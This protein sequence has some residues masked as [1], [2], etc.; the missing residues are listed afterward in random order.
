[1]IAVPLHFERFYSKSL[2]WNPIH[3]TWFHAYLHGPWLNSNGWLTPLFVYLAK[4]SGP[5]ECISFV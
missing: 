3:T 2:V 4:G 5:E 1:M